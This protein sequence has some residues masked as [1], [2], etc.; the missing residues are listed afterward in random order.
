MIKSFDTIVFIA[1]TS[2]SITLSLT[3]IGLI[4]VPISSFIACG[5]TISNKILYEV[6]LQKYNKYTKQYEEDIKKLHLLINY[7]KKVCKVI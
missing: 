4:V 7:I 2:S 5:L 1:L 6:A 3:G